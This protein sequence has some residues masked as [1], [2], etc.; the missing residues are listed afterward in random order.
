MYQENCHMWWKMSVLLQPWRIETVAR[1]QSTCQTHRKKIGSAPNNILCLVELWS[2]DSLGVSSKRTCSRCESL[3]SINRT[4]SWILRRRYPALVNRNRVILQQGN[5]RS[6]T[7]RTTMTNIQELR[8]IE[9]VPHPAYRPDLAPSDYHLFQSMANFLLGI[10]F[11]NIET[12]DVG[13]RRIK[14][15]RLVPSR[16]NKHR[17]KNGWWFL[18]WGIV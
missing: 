7:A 14:N 16:D 4:S 9:L 8:G 1:S 11:E 6:H 15:Q 17:W 12:V 10:N 18:L 13:I 5:A 2:C 3:F